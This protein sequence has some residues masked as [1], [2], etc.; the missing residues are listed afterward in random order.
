MV[1]ERLAKDVY[2]LA[3]ERLDRFSESSFI[4][5]NPQF[6]ELAEGF[7]HVVQFLKDRPAMLVDDATKPNKLIGFMLDEVREADDAEKNETRDAY[8]K[9]LGDCG[10]FGLLVGGLF[11]D[12][13]GHVDKTAVVVTLE[14]VKQKASEHKIDL[15]EAVVYVSDTKNAG[16]Y[17]TE[18]HQLI[19]DESVDSVRKRVPLIRTLH[20]DLRE[21]LN[22]DWANSNNLLITLAHYWLD[23]LTQLDAVTVKK[24]EQLF[25]L[26]QL[27]LLWYAEAT[28]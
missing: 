15:N 23:T 13:L 9:E 17:R 5:D 20:R 12:E 21:Q 16:N 18:L 24:I 25:E 28:S 10:F 14:Y 3:V 7:R 8:I 6:L 26:T 11:W 22:G 2:D 27:D 4:L 19:P 1:A